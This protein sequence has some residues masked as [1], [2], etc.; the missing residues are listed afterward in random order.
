MT[1]GY[2]LLALFW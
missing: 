2:M 1:F